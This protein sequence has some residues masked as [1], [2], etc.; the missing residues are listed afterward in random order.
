MSD[1]VV[2][3]TDNWDGHEGTALYTG[4]N[5]AEVKAFFMADFGTSATLEYIIGDNND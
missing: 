2:F 5:F 3:Y 4:R 1:Y